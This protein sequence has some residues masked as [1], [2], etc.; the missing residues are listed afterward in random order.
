MLKFS[1]FHPSKLFV[2][3]EGKTEAF[4]DMQKQREFTTYI[5]SLKDILKNTLQKNDRLTQK[6]VKKLSNNGESKNCVINDYL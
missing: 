4:T 5:L 2:R 1:S 3:K 6:E